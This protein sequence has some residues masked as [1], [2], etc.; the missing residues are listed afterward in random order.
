[1]TKVLRTLVGGG[2]AA[3]LGVV[4]LGVSGVFSAGS[5]HAESPPN[6][7]SRIAGSVLV[8]GQP[9]PAGTAIIAKVGSATCGTTSTFTEGGASRY[10][11]D[12]AAIDPGANPNCG[13]DNSPVTFLIGDKPAKE[14]GTWN[15]GVLGIVNL[16]YVTP[17][18]TA[19]T[20]A[21]TP[22]GGGATPGAPSTGSGY[23]S[24][25]DSNLWLLIALGAGALAFG[26]GGTL[27]A[28]R[29]R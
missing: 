7:P 2:L 5:A 15:N 1:M 18:P 29:S 20:T 24:A 17:T 11:V 16:T 25:S 10:V 26:V 3:V 4:L 8:D 13:A 28:R 12:V 9:V 21:T 27:A 23:N 19:T 6:P 22:T 14:S